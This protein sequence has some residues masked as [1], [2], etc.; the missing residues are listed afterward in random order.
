[1][2]N[3]PILVRATGRAGELPPATRATLAPARNPN[4]KPV[5]SSSSGGRPPRPGEF[6]PGRTPADSPPPS[7]PSSLCDR[8]NSGGMT[9]SYRLPSS[10]YSSLLSARTSCPL[11]LPIVHPC[12]CRCAIPRL[13]P[14]LGAGYLQST[15]HPENHACAECA[16][17]AQFRHFPG[18]WSIPKGPRRGGEWRGPS[19]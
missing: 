18:T 5:F 6:A 8:R 11:I 19:R 10:S 17:G 9:L 12:S 14:S 13:A 15:N 7:P 4:S 16:T 3:R 2:S 1:M